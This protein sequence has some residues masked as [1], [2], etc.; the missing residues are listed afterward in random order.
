MFSMIGCYFNML[1]PHTNQH[2]EA[3]TGIIAEL[4]CMIETCMQTVF[5]LNSWW[6]RIKGQHQIKEKPGRQYVT[7]LLIANIC[8]WIINTLIKG[9][10]GF[11]PLHMDVFGAWAWTIMTHISMPLGIFYRFHSSICLY[12]IWKASY[13][14]KTSFGP[15]GSKKMSI[16]S[17]FG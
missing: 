7:F 3:V 4:F 10:A 16:F 8:L 2:N 14:M 12:E 9:R 6:R 5:I 11:R 15:N 13:K 1:D 17:N